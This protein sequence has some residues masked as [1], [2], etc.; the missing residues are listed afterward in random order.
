VHSQQFFDLAKQSITDQIDG[1]SSAVISAYNVQGFNRPFVVTDSA[2]LVVTGDTPDSYYVLGLTE[3]ALQIVQSE[4]QEVESDLVTGLEQ[5][6]LRI[7]GEHAYNVGVK[8]FKWDVT[9]GG[10]NPDDTA[11][12][13]GSNWDMV[14]TDNRDLAGVILK[15][16]ASS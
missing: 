2:S 1:I 13:T 3:D 12:G 4:D 15:C 10:A 16:Q 9:S 8:G 6:V 5:L 14:A 7:Q 11:V